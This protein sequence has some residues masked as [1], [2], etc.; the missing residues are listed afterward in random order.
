MALTKK[1]VHRLKQAMKRRM[2]GLSLS[3]KIRNEKLR[4]RTKITDV[5]ERVTQLTDSQKL[6][7]SGPKTVIF[8][9]EKKMPISSSG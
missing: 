2:L 8:E 5:L 9:R 1:N 6:V 4:R 7:Q 3:D